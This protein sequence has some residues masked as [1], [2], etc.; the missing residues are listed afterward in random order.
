MTWC[1]NTGLREGNNIKLTTD[2]GLS[3]VM[4]ASITPIGPN[5]DPSFR[6]SK[7]ASRSH[8]NSEGV[9]LK[10][11]GLDERNRQPNSRPSAFPV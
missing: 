3:L 2:R 4:D 9:D 1:S 8:L 11:P 6:P 10:A 7:R 5:G